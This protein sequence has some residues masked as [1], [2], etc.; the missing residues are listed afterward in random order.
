MAAALVAQALLERY[1]SVESVTLLEAGTAVEA[2]N[3]RTWLDYVTTGANPYREHQDLDSEVRSA[4]GGVGLTESRLFVRGGSTEHWGGWAP[5][6][7]PEDFHLQSAA[8]RELDWPFGYDELEPYYAAAEQALGVMGHSAESVPPR[9]GRSYPY[10][11]PPFTQADGVIIAALENEGIAHSHLP[12]A[13]F[14]DRCITTGTCKYCP[15][16]ARY[17]ASM[18]LDHLERAH[19]PSGRFELRLDSVVRSVAM[20]AP[21][22]AGGVDYLDRATRAVRRLPSDVVILAAGAIES[23]KIL[24]A[25]HHPRWPHGLGNQS[26]H[27]GRHFKFHPM[28]RAEGVLPSNP[29][30]IHQEIDFPTLCSRHFDDETHQH[31]GKLF[32]VR[33]VP[34]P[35]IGVEALMANGRELAF[36]EDAT[37]GAMRLTLSGFVEPFSSPADRIALGDGLTRFGLP[38]TTIHYHP[39][40]EQT[41][42]MERH[43][44]TFGRILRASGAISIRSGLLPA[45]A[46]HAASTTRM[47]VSDTDGVVDPELRVH[48]MENLYVCSSSVFPSL[49]AVNPTLTIAA[50]ALRLGETLGRTLASS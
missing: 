20:A 6:F 41:E 39:P 31:T 21:H 9:R 8:G 28:L 47:S 34:A 15:V 29:S 50:L 11:A 40:V 24:L 4:P 10:E 13:R 46:D 1:P 22:R 27:L 32:F 5:R 45:R 33:S 48:G 35:D 43:L 17:A 12:I 19:G 44:A 49:A 23:P 38:R 2:R 3:R 7:K 14:A 18:T 25:S 26:G 37:R 36:I 30:R 16:G 42:T